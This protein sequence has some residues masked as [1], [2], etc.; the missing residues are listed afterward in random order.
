MVTTNLRTL[1]CATLL[2]AAAAPALAGTASFIVVHGIP[3]R[4]VAATLDPAL[5]VDVQVNG[6]LCLLQS[7]TYGDIAGPFDVPS[8]TYTVAI[9]LANPLAPCSN[10][11]VITGSA[12]LTDGQ[13]GA[14]VAQLSTKGAPT[15]GVY[16]VDVSSVGAGN[17]RFVVVHAAD[18]PKVT[19]NAISLGKS[20][21]KLKFQISPGDTK[22]NT[23][24]ARN[25]FAVELIAPGGGVFGP[26]KVT[27]GDQSLF[28]VAAV[29]NANTGSV[30]LLSKLIRSVF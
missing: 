22:T 12:T 27:G 9:S 3:G 14:I 20:P 11:P 6:K 2:S 30:A 19:I 8:G 15:A 5:P 16:P 17:Q 10:A 29:G 18:A 28:F 24:P 23:V 7:F 13:F 26:I 21:E 25:G 1:L 4:D